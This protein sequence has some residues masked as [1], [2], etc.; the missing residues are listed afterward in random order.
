MIH[1]TSKDVH[2]IVEGE[3]NDPIIQSTD[4]TT[5]YVG[6]TEKDGFLLTV[7]FGHK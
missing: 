1:K 4:E 6:L 7:P 5:K 2:F 3:L